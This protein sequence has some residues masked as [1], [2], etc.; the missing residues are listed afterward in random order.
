METVSIAILRKIIFLVLFFG[1]W[2]S[3]DKYYLTAFDT[4]E[5]LKNDPKAVAILLGLVSIAA[6]L[7]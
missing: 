1:A 4:V 7:A 6:A 3:F 5:V 2:I